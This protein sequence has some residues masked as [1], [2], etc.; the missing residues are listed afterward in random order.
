MVLASCTWKGKPAPAAEGASS[1]GDLPAGTLAP[2]LAASPTQESQPPTATPEAEMSSRTLYTLTA[3][4]DY[5]LH[6]LSVEE[7]VAYTNRTGVPLQELVLIVEANRYPGTFNLKHL[8]VNGTAPPSA[9]TLEANQMRLP[10]AN[11]LS[12]GEVLNLSLTYD[13]N[14]PSPTPSPLTR[15]VPFGTTP[16]Q[17]NL[18]DWYPYVPPYDSV[19]GWLAHAPGYFGEHQVYE[20]ADFVVNLRITGAPAQA[21]ASSSQTPS[22]TIAASAVPQIDGEWYRYRFENARNFAWS[23]SHDYLL[24]TRT[25]GD[26]AIYSYAFPIHAAAGKASLETTANAL[27]LYNELFAPYPRQSLSVVEADFLDGMEYDGL[28]F[29][30]NGF[31]N[32]YSGKPADYLVS[33]AAHETA[34]QWF[35]ALVGNDQAEEP[36][37]DE[38]LCTYSERLYY[39]R[40]APEALDWWWAYRIRYYDPRG[41]IDG[42]IYSYTYTGEAYRAY[43]DAVYLNG[44]L[45]LEELRTQLGDQAFFSFLQDYVTRSAYSLA[46]GDTFFAV[47]QEHTQ[48]DLTALLDKYFAN[49]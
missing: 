27:A 5:A 6:H 3:T 12:P 42:S 4:L 36:W 47:L 26:V 25:V 20:S 31:Y 32:L 40:F 49:R 43:R 48:A 11:P 21:G 22:L 13:L 8:E 46:S 1:P 14:L 39:E 7:Q 17:T 30:S 9:Y 2:A 38:A 34:H 41:W 18:V 23:A 28:Y 16:R 37:L 29:L 45:F 33:I 44:A 19:K 35:Y 10:L 15:P 24:T